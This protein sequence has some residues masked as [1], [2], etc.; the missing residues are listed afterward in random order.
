[1]RKI[2]AASAVGLALIAGQAI[3][4]NGSAHSLRAGDRVGAALGG[5]EDNPL[6]AWLAGGGFF[7]GAGVG[8]AIITSVIIA[9]V[10]IPVIDK[11]ADEI[12][13]EDSPST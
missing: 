10:A 7:G 1:M 12:D 11:V 9:A 2:I 5:T 6:G 3:A 4:A 13:G 8:G